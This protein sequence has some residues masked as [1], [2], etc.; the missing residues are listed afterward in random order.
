MKKLSIYI[1]L[2]TSIINFSC[3]KETT[4]QSYLVESQEKKGFITVDIPASVVQL[5]NDKASEE[6]KETYESIRKINITGLPYKNSDDATYEAEKSKLK[7]I[8]KNSSYKQ[9][10]SFKKDGVSAGVYY[11]GEAD[12]INEIVAIG[13]GKEFGVGVARIL[14]EK[15]NPSKII[16]MMQNAK[17]DAEGINMEQIKK[18]LKE[19]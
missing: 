3:K 10:M 8:I 18:I 12:A 15:M 13:Y 1:L 16:D 6:D 17:I 7:E 14:G 4:L 19:D 2:L 11:S 5:S 9:L